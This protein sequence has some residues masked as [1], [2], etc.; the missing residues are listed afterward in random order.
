MPIIKVTCMFYVH[1]PGG[2]WINLA[3]VRR[4]DYEYEPRLTVIVVWSDEL[5]RLYYDEKALAIL[6]ALAESEFIDKSHVTSR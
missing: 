4:L 5:Q 6:E 1:L 3:K 2:E